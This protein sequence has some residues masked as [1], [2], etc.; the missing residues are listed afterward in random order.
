MVGLIGRNGAG[1]TTTLRAVMGVAVRQAGE[2]RAAPWRDETLKAL[3]EM[4]Q[5]QAAL[6]VPPQAGRGIS[7]RRA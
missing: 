5:A 4:R 1:K 2:T 6:P 3:E 7:L